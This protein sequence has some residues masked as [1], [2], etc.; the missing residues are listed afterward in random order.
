MINGKEMANA[1]TE[2]ND[3]I[4]QRERF[5]QQ[6]K[7]MERGDEEAMY[8][9]YD[10]LAPLNMACHQQQASVSVSTAFAC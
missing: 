5:E 3:P 7:L 4:D 6:A 2:L 9:D 8:I 10:F 1:Y